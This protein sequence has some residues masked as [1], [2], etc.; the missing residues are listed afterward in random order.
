MNVGQLKEL[1]S[2]VLLSED[3]LTLL[4]ELA[5]LEHAF[6]TLASNPADTAGQKAVRAT[7]DQVEA[8]TEIF[9][10]TFSGADK[11]RLEELGV[12]DVVGRGMMAKIEESIRQNPATPAV[13]Q[14]VITQLRGSLE[15]SLERLRFLQEGLAQYKS[16][17]D[18]NKPGSAE[19]GFKIPR[20]LFNNELEGLI[21]ELRSIRLI[22]RA[23]AELKTQSVGPIEVHQISTSDPLFFFGL[24]P[25]VVAEI[26]LAI[27]WALK[28]WKDLEVIRKL[29]TETARLKSWTVEE[30]ESFFGK[31][32]RETIDSAVK[33]KVDK[34]LP[35]DGKAGRPAEQRS[36]LTRA[37][38][39]I[40]ARVER[41]MTVEVRFIPPPQATAKGSKSPPKDKNYSVYETL[42]SVGPQLVFPPPDPAPV[43]QLPSPAR[44]DKGAA[45]KPKKTQKR[46][47]TGTNAPPTGE[48][49]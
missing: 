24:D 15:L 8:A 38:E 26:A 2:R 5:K 42:K 48:Q 39:S 19:I 17:D 47:A 12:I 44:S 20:S 36:D 31:K 7:L 49:G 3:E 34:L 9:E 29:R 35:T 6:A 10:G 25:M 16:A 21:S 45:T 11:E 22:V 41:G 30:M 14:D 18:F 32:I 37:L 33:A 46:R 4:S 13:V 1:A 40:L 23:F 28:T 43:T 27:T